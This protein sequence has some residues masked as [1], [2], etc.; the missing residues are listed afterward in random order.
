MSRKKS[1]TLELPGAAGATGSEKKSKIGKNRVSPFLLPPIPIE[2]LK[3]PSEPLVN[4]F[5][6]G[7]MEDGRLGFPPDVP[8]FVQATPRPVAALRHLRKQ[9]RQKEIP[10]RAG[11]PRYVCKKVACGYRHTLMWMHNCYPPLST[12]PEEGVC[13]LAAI[14]VLMAV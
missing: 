4:V 5:A 13:M 12:A 1:D 8:S 11:E 10:G 14:L 7:W 9:H 2:I 3:P 6:F